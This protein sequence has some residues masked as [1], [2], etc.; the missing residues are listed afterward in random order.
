MHQPF[1]NTQWKA[2]D[3]ARALS[4]LSV[5]ICHTLPLGPK[6]IVDMNI[7]V[8]QFGM[9]IFFALSGFL[10]AHKLLTNPSL[11]DFAVN[12]FVRIVPLLWLLLAANVVF[13]PSSLGGSAISAQFFMYLNNTEYVFLKDLAHLWSICV[14]AHFYIVTAL[15]FFV[16]RRQ[17]LWLLVGLGVA[18]TFY[19]GYEMALFNPRTIFRFDE[20][21][22]GMSIGLLWH[23]NSPWAEA[24]KQFM[25]KINPVFVFLAIGIASLAPPNPTLFLM[26]PYL[27]ALLVGVLIF[28]T[29]SPS[30]RFLSSDRWQWLSKHTY[31][32]YLIH[33]F[34]MLTWLGSGDKM[35]MY[36]K[37]PLLFVVLFVLAYLSTRYYEKFFI[38]L[39]K[40]WVAR[41]EERRYGIANPSPGTNAQ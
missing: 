29:S 7:A 30:I 27:G 25:S 26:R 10:I 20:L 41:R 8:G 21:L 6:N 39:G 37:R 15:C 14:E 40:R 4:I 5:L 36:M 19:R 33:P 16:F 34:L 24:V 1:M 11:F 23:S 13:N 3:G 35:V 31:A 38:K 2:L 18:L 17:G 22:I 9:S 32:L 28:N 12:R